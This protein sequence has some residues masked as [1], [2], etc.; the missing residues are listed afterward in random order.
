MIRI[1]PTAKLIWLPGITR[2]IAARAGNKFFGI[3]QCRLNK[4]QFFNP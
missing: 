3:G 1:F 2:P 4:I